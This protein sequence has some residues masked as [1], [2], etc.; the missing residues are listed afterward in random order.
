MA[1][2]PKRGKKIPHIQKEKSPLRKGRNKLRN[3]IFRRSSVILV[4]IPAIMARA[5]LGKGHI[6]H[7]IR[8]CQNFT[9]LRHVTN[10]EHVALRWKHYE[11]MLKR[12]VPTN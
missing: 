3:M 4:E 12:L 1:K 7:V 10:K 2:D 6:D 9:E 11:L 8:D 5:A